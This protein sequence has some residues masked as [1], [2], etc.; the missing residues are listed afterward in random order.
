VLSR[1]HPLTVE[2]QDIGSFELT[3]T[4]G[5]GRQDYTVSYVERRRGDRDG[6]PAPLSG[7]NLRLAGKAVPLKVVSSRV[8]RATQR[9]ES[10]ASG[11][12]TRDLLQTFAAS[13]SRSLVVETASADDS[14]T[15]IRVGNAGMTTGL[16]G[17]EARC[18]AGSPI[19]NTARTSVR[20][21]G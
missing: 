2:G 6:A 17:L 15:A 13:G 14:D 4:C 10:T 18:A 1:S 7:V 12:M 8:K 9:L 3:F 16:R 21:G 11:T 5:A 19:R 20:Q